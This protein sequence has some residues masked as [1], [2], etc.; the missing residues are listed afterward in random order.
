MGGGGTTSTSTST[1]PGAA[2]TTNTS[3]TTEIVYETVELG[4]NFSRLSFPVP[5]NQ[6]LSQSLWTLRNGTRVALLQPAAE[7]ASSTVVTQTLTLEGFDLHVCVDALASLRVLRGQVMVRGGSANC[8][9]SPH[10]LYSH[11]WWNRSSDTPN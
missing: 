6:L 11:G 4:A 2:A 8:S 10:E 1:L 9:M 5:L 7:H 3:T